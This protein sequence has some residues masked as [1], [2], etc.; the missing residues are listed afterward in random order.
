MKINIISLFITCLMVTG[1]QAQIDRSVQ[2]QPGPAPKINLEKPGDFDLDNGLEVLVVEDHSLPKVTARLVI[3]NKP[4]LEKKPGTSSLLSML[5]GTGTEKIGKDEYIEEIDFLGATVNFGSE[6]AYATSLSKY[7]PRI[8]E[9]MAAGALH[10][11][12]DQQEFEDQK[13]KLIQSL[14]FDDKSVSAIASR[15]SGVLAY[16]KNHPYGQFATEESVEK[17]TLNDVVAFYNNYFV[18][19]NAY[20]VVVGDITEKEVKKL[21]EKY[22]NEKNWPSATPPSAALPAV[23]PAQYTQIDFVDMPNAVQSEL[24]IQNTVDLQMSDEDYFPVLV[25]NQILGGSFGSYLNMN[26]REEHGF[27]YGARSRVGTDKYVSKFTASTSVRNAVTDSAVVQAMKE[28]GRIRTEKVSFED[29]N[30]AKNKFAGNFVLRLERPRTIAN[31]ALNIR[32]KD[33]DDDFYKNYLKNINA[34]TA[35]DVMRVANKYFKTDNMQIVVAGKGAEV[36]EN[37]ENLQ[38]KNGKTP[39]VV[40]YDKMGNRIEKPVYEKPIPEGVTAATVFA[41]YLEA[42]GGEE[43]VKNVESIVMKAE[44]AVQGMKINLLR[45][46]KGNKSL[47][48]VSMGGNVMSKEVFN[49]ETGYTLAGGQKTP[50]DEEKIAEGKKAKMFPELDS[51]EATLEKVANINGN[52][53][54]VVKIDENT[55]AYY[56]TETGYKTRSET[57]SKANGKTITQTTTFSNYKPVNGVEFPFTMTASFGPRTMEMTVTEVKVNEGVTAADFE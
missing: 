22:M 2:P 17:I 24:R 54:Y 55:T 6:S 19:E 10:P 16:G 44:M 12:F 53:V 41:D 7:F 42:I 43:A 1:L 5:L 30:L 23:S 20:L 28:I 13:D 34:V 36:A 31:F 52:E 48:E 40:Y 50:Y 38:L 15:L 33:L 46:E 47:V 51:P 9:L 45:K 39:P 18:P 57:V 49:G 21:A 35:E 27:T 32:T 8:F 3:D 26:L 25:A 14:K 4:H 11:K 56:D 37:L 29:L